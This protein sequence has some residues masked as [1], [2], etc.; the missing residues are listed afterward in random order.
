MRGWIP[1]SQQRAREEA[2]T[3]VTAST[4]PR[5]EAKGAPLWRLCLCRHRQR[6]TASAMQKNAPRVKTRGGDKGQ[7]HDKVDSEH[8][9]RGE[10]KC[11]P[12]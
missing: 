12:L 2:E 8:G 10:G 9:L 3:R 5:T 1:E 6:A 7:G 11:T 4:P